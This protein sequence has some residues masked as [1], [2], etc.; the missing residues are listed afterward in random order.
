MRSQMADGSDNLIRPLVYSD[1]LQATRRRVRSNMLA[2][3]A[4]IA[5]SGGVYRLGVSTL[6]RK[7]GTDR[8]CTQRVLADLKA[9]GLITVDYSGEGH[10]GE[11]RIYITPA[12]WAFRAEAMAVLFPEAPQL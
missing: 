6:A 1:R 5:R 12:G 10:T 9:W 11:V 2:A 7:A 8:K 3:F 4:E